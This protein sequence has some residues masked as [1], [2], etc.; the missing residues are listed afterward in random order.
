[1]ADQVYGGADAETAETDSAVTATAGI[2]L[3]WHGALATH[4]TIPP[5]AAQPPGSTRCGKSRDGTT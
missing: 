3:T 4:I 2:V 5:A 1:M